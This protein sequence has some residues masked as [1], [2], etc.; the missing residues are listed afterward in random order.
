MCRNDGVQQ[1]GQISEQPVM[2]LTTANEVTIEDCSY[3]ESTSCSNDDGEGVVLGSIWSTNGRVHKEEDNL[4]EFDKRRG[5]ND[6]TIVV[7][8]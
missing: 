1:V 2:R 6:M 5:T 3:L 7:V 8:G 4:E